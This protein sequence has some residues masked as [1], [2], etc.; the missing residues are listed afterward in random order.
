MGHFS[1]LSRRFISKQ[2]LRDLLGSAFPEKEIDAMIKEAASSEQGIT[3]A[4]F[5]SQWNTDK[6]QFM[7][8]WTQHMVPESIDADLQGTRK[9]SDYSFSDDY[10]DVDESARSNF[11]DGK[12]V[13]LRKMGNLDLAISA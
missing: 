7:R 8:E 2:N 3:Y 11:L 1:G 5:L 4:D 13:S 12:D 10:R 9:V 6:D